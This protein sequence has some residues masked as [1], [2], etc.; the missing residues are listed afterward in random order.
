MAEPEGVEVDPGCRD[1]RGAR[2]ERLVER[3]RVPG[4]VDEDQRAPGLD[5]QLQETDPFRVEVTLAVRARRGPELPVEV[6][7]PQAW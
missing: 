6:V 2:A 5:L 7:G 3:R 1:V 4:R